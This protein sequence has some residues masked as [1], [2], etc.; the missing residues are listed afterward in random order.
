MVSGGPI[1]ANLSERLEGVRGVAGKAGWKEVSGSPTYCNDDPALAV[2]QLNDLTTA[3]A[4]LNAAIAVGGWPPFVPEGYRN[5][6][7]SNADRFKS[8]K[9]VAVA[10]DTLSAELQLLR[11]G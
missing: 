1:G 8:G 7:D 2:Q 10:A 11:A 3:H 6:G 5:W 9:P 4:D